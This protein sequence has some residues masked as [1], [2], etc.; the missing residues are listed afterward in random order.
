M[1]SE[2]SSR[3]SAAAVLALFTLAAAPASALRPDLE[4]G[5]VHLDLTQTTS[6]L[7]NSD[8][9]DTRAQ[10]VASLANDQWA[11]IYNRLNVQA[12]R[13]RFTL[14]LRLDG[15][16]FPRSPTPAGIA[17]QLARKE[18]FDQD[19]EQQSFYQNKVLEAGIE[20]SNRYINWI[21]PAKVTL[22]YTTPDLEISLGDTT[23]QLG[24]GLVLSVRKMD[25]LASD[26]SIR[27]VRATANFRL[28]GSRL[29]LD[30]L[31]G[32]LNPL[33]IDEASGRYLGVDSSVTPGFLRLTEAGMP[34]AIETD[35]VKNGGN[36]SRFGTC[37]YAPD[38]VLAG[39]IEIGLSGITLGTQ[40]SLLLRQDALSPDLSRSARTVATA[41]QSFE[42]PRWLEH[43]SF[44]AELALQNLGDTEQGA[45]APALGHALYGTAS[46][47]HPS[48][49]LLLE[50]KHYRRFFPLAANLKSSRA[51][52]FSLLQYSAPPTTETVWNDT[53][54]GNFDTCV[55]GGRLRA[56]LHPRRAHSVYGWIGHARSF[57]E[58]VT[59]AE[60]TISARN[61]NRIW[62]AAIG[63]RLEK[64]EQDA[65]LDLSL[66]ARFD[67]A[68]RDLRGPH[69]VT[70]VFYR[71][72][73]LRYDGV[74]PLSGPFALEL[75]G[76]HR[77]RREVVGGPNQAWLEGHHS[78]GLDW[79]ERLSLAV[80]FEYDSRPD[81]PDRF[82]NLMANWRPTE[83]TVLGLF[84]GQRRGSLRCVGGVCRVYPPFE[85][86]RLDFTYR[87]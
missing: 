87:Y 22:L 7:Y 38:R 40:A 33:R 30:L 48:F 14:R 1:I 73:S 63:L 47:T 16:W 76:V 10:E 2:T 12:T 53:Q 24:R 52:E 46:W 25:E 34:R 55:T 57:S 41:S 50:G 78:T 5:P 13:G 39:Q 45:P 8:N 6:F 27:G 43:G 15:V 79:G 82:W 62:D 83:A 35:F 70:R 37:S 54:F 61:E 77:R 66:G 3:G 21:Y 44:Y 4:E 51:R 49:S 80:G 84:L 18:R 20:L 59:N 11:V 69:G 72:S 86:F 75:S 74:L 36:C 31:F 71:E 60:C 56:A 58:S 23:A 42:A 19:E 65:S 17:S 67:D 64:P 81:T 28:P 68:G 32:A 26:Q 85:G 29:K 9:R